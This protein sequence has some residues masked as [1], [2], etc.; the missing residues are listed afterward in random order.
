MCRYE[1]L[2]RS[3][4]A[5]PAQP[6]AEHSEPAVRTPHLHTG[7]RC[8]A[9]SEQTV[10][11]PGGMVG[12][13]VRLVCT[14][15]GVPVIEPLFCGCRGLS[16]Q[17]EHERYLAEEYCKKLVLP[18]L[19]FQLCTADRGTDHFWVCRPVFVTDYPQ[20]LKPFYMRRTSTGVTSDPLSADPRAT[21]LH[22]ICFFV[23]ERGSRNRNSSH[24]NVVVCRWRAWTCLCRRSAN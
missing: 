19:L 8:A 18:H 15:F 2:R 22:F 17:S 1:F 6:L 14:A 11:I 24:Q 23:R 4:G 12:C 10:Q 3:S 21:V 5:G 13:G 7:H 16:L 9:E 20:A